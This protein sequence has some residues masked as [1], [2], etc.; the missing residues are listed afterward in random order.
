[1]LTTA[2]FKKGARVELDGQP[3]TVVSVTTQSPSAR[4]QA[5]LVK[6]R[7]RNI[8]TGQVTDRS[9]RAGEKFNAPD[10]VMRPASYLYETPGSEPSYVFMDQEN[11]EQFELSAE[12]LGEDAEWLSEG[13]EVRAIIYNERVCAVELPQFV[14]V[15]LDYVEPGTRGDTASGSVTTTAVTVKGRKLQVPLYVESGDV[16]RVDLSTGLFKDRV[17]G[18]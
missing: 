10:L 18:R 13:L 8:L 7:L 9:F 4:G 2:D 17:G 1:M 15:Q 14:E 5:T 16:V 6:A 3:W 11:Y 12:L